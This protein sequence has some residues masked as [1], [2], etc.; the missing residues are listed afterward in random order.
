MRVARDDLHAVGKAADVPS[1]QE[2]GEGDTVL[3]SIAPSRKQP[4]GIVKLKSSL[5]SRSMSCEAYQ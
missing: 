4:L 1:G 2:M 3:A 5:E